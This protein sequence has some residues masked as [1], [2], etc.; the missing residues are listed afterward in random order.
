MIEIL[1]TLIAL[2]LFATWGFAGILITLMLQEQL[3]QDISP[4][5]QAVM[6]FLLGP[7]IWVVCIIVCLSET[8]KKG[9]E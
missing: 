5:R 7:V 2:G 9:N 8:K 6:I 4:W 1:W 3:K